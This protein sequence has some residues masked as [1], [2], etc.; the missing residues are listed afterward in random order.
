MRI[1]SHSS[2]SATVYRVGAG[3][4]VAQWIRRAAKV[5][6][7]PPSSFWLIADIAAMLPLPNPRES[8]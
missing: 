4:R 7:V 3:R 1:S 5:A 8:E 6:K 2:R